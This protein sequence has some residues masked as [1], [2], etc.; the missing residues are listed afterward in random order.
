M[1]KLLFSVTVLLLGTAPSAK[2]Q[3][4]SLLFTNDHHICAEG[5]KELRFN[6]DNISF[7]RDNEYESRLVKD[8]TLPGFWVQPSISYQPLSNLK[9]EVGMYL[10]R[11]WGA[12]NYPSMNYSGIA[13]WNGEKGQ[14]GFHCRPMFRVQMALSPNFSIVLGTLY[15]KNDHHL[16]E[17]LYNRELGLTA[18]PEAGV[19][20]LCDT[21]PFD[22]DLWV[23]WENFIFHNDDEQEAFTF[24]LSS[25]F[26]TGHPDARTRAYIPLQILFKHQGGKINPQA[27]SREIK[28]WANAAAGVGMD[29]RPRHNYF[30]RLNLEALAVGFSQQKGTAFPWNKGFGLYGKATADLWRFRISAGYWTCNHFITINGNP[31][32]NAMSV[33]GDGL[34]LKRPRTILAGLEYSQALAKGFSW[35]IHGE[36][37]SQLATDAHSPEHGFYREG[38]AMSYACAIYLRINPSVLIHRF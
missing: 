15:G 27:D 34:T 12:N 21:R 17:P 25:R 8:Y 1:R 2:A 31:L 36:L 14:K 38:S 5:K 11:Y 13:E 26:K 22:M 9:V 16:V 20:L 29:I 24:G 6:V 19:Q 3:M 30:T 37:Y 10:L 4:D 18:D 28:T 32:Y 35:A 33:S 7:M 23:N